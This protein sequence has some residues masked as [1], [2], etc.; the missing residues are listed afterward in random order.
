MTVSGTYRER[1]FLR[2]RLTALSSSSVSTV[3][4]FMRFFCL[5]PDF[6]VLLK[7]FFSSKMAELSDWDEDTSESEWSSISPSEGQASL[8][9]LWNLR[10]FVP[11]AALGELLAGSQRS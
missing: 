1:T 10:L 6:L 4:L 8:G 9:L 2:A 7:Y 11:P 3:V 5:V